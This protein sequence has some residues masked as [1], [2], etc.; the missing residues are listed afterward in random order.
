[1][2]TILFGPFLLKFSYRRGGHLL[3]AIITTVLP[4]LPSDVI[5][6]FPGIA[7]NAGQDAIVYRIPCISL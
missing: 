7:K 3:V 4:P 1:M 2:I 5:D 6:G